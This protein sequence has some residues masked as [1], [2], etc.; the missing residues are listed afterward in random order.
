MLVAFS[1]H[2][3]SCKS[4]IISSAIIFHYSSPLRLLMKSAYDLYCNESAAVR[5]MN[6][7]TF[8]TIFTK[9]VSKS[10]LLAIYAL[11][12]IVEVGT[13]PQ[14]M[15]VAATRTCL[16]A[17]TT[18]FG[19]AR[20]SRATVT[21]RLRRNGNW[22][23]FYTISNSHHPLL[24]PNLPRIVQTTTHPISTAHLQPPPP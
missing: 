3:F 16:F 13:V 11:P 15:F 2:G 10:F 12:P 17:G 22:V 21:K 19:W 8:P 7:P 6:H 20:Q 5:W 4:V 23:A 9:D 18:N 24:K 14:R 1:Q